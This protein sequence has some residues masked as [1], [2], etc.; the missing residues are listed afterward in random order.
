MGGYIAA[1]VAVAIFLLAGVGVL[2]IRHKVRKI[3]QAFFGTDSFREGLNQT[4][5]DVAMTPKSVSSMTRLMEP[6]IM[7]DFPDFSWPQF[8]DKAENMLTSALLAIS[9]GN[10]DLLQEAS[11]DIR[12]QIVNRIEANRASGVQEIYKDIRIH[13]TE[14]SNYH[15]ENGK[16]IVTIQSAVQY[17]HYKMQGDWIVEGSK[18]LFHQTKYNMQLMYIQDERL[19]KLDNAVG[20][21]CPNCGA[22]VRQLGTMRCEY[23]GLAVTP[24]NIKVWSLH[25]LQE[26]DYNHV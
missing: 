19:V 24:V 26:V 11:E 3:S 6:Q 9:A 2:V 14:I 8:R 15:K 21:T 25:K 1:G 13:Q 23:C 20:T 7:R 18:E 17:Y 4:A 5:K 16:C 10:A 22:P 12:R